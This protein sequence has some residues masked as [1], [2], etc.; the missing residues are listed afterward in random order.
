MQVSN[1][2]C[3]TYKHRYK[4]INV[5]RTMV[6]EYS[7]DITQIRNTRP[8]VSRMKVLVS[9]CGLSTCIKVLID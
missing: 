6:E 8:T 4:S 9:R 5:S 3:V 1:S 7:L 2:T